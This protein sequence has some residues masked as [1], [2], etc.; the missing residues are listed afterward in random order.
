MVVFLK[1]SFSVL[2]AFLCVS[3]FVGC[4]S[5]PRYQQPKLQARVVDLIEQEGYRFKDLNRNQQLDPYEDWRLA[6]ALRAQDLLSQM[7]LEQQVGFMLISTIRMENE[8]GFGVPSGE[9][10]PLGEGFSEVDV[11][12]DVNFFTRVPM[13]DSFMSSAGTT[14]AVRDFN[15]RHFILRA[16]PG[17]GT[18]ASWQ[19]NL[20][21]FCE[22]QPLGIPA[23]V[24]SNPRNHVTTDASVGLSL[25]KTSFS[26]WPGELGLSASR[27]PKLIEQFADIARQEWRA[28]GLRKGYMY[29]A[30]LST[31]PRW[32]RIEGTFGEDHEWV[33]QVMTALVKGFQGTR[34]SPQ[35]VALTTKH[36]PGGGSHRRGPRSSL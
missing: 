14:K 32:Q 29:M 20:Q 30:D 5:S 21:T 6:P 15:G 16:N 1:R 7:T 17:V 11:E 22:V 19:N 26:Q 31:E 13:N 27:D 9:K 36:F 18:L 33:A 28:V 23:I 3:F 4:E 8:A 2:S 24:A 12:F 10:K 25:G 35:S 34:L